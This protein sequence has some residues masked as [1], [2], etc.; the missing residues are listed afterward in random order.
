MTSKLGIRATPTY[1]IRISRNDISRVGI[2]SAAH[3]QPLHH[4]MLKQY[5]AIDRLR[6]RFGFLKK[7]KRPNP[8][9]MTD[10]TPKP[11]K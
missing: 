4:E 7:T 2:W 10:V 8:N 9:K 1:S 11:N 3:S 5:Q 6:L